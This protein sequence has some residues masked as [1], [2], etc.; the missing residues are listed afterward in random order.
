MKKGLLSFLSLAFVVAFSQ[1]SIA[2]VEKDVKKAEI[3]LKESQV[4]WKGKKL[5]GEHYGTIS[6]KSGQLLLDGNKLTGGS[7]E[8]DMTSINNTDLTDEDSNKKLVG[9]LKSEDFF[10]VENH[11]T[12]K[13]E[14]TKVEH[15]GG[16][17]YNLTGNLTIKGITHPIS[18]PATVSNKGG[19][20]I[21]VADMKFDR[22]KYDVKYGSKSFFDNIGDKVI[23]DEVE[24]KV[25]LVSANTVAVK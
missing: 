2:G 7:F 5:T 12:S 8:I 19:K 3:D 9:H 21:A 11:P 16:E 14:I 17:K 6:L 20:V 24:M 10:S 22:S 13:F 15:K 25:N 1:V 4:E 18:F 23:Y